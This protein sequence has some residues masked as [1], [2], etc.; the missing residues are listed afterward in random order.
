[1]TNETSSILKIYS[2][3]NEE[4]AWDTNA[5][6][7]HTNGK[8]TVAVDCLIFYWL[9]PLSFPETETVVDIYF[10]LLCSPH[11]KKNRRSGRCQPRSP[12]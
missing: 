3:A 8:E 5:D 6:D 11:G 1:M 4:K 12:N 9:R 10:F 7:R 2:M